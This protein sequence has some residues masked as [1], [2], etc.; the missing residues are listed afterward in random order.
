MTQTHTYTTR[1][2]DERS[3][4]VYDWT[5]DGDSAWQDFVRDATDADAKL[6]TEQGGLRH[7]IENGDWFT[8]SANIEAA[9][10]LAVKGWAEGRDKAEALSDKMV[11]DYRGT[12]HARKVEHARFGPGTIDAGRYAQGH[13][14]SIIRSVPNP[15][16]KVPHGVNVHIGFNASVSAVV[17]T[18]TMIERGAFICALVDWLEN[19]GAR[20]ELTFLSAGIWTGRVHGNVTMNRWQ[21]RMTVKR[22]QDSLNLG[23]VAFAIA[24]PSTFRRLVFGFMEQ[25]W[26]PIPGNYGQPATYPDIEDCVI[27]PQI[28]SRRDIPDMQAR[29][30]EQLAERGIYVDWGE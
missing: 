10:E 18:D 24:H 19:H 27:V 8:G 4:Y 21:V 26:P 7:S 12:D 23:R 22:L 1:T 20:V 17:S 30:K 14:M 6:P 25:V 16:A 9:M 13:P 28:Y 29:T 5:F 11:A 2:G 15:R 3:G